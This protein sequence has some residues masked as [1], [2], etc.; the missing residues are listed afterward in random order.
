VRSNSSDNL[1]SSTDS[2]TK[3]SYIDLFKIMLKRK[4]SKKFDYGN[5]KNIIEESEKV[6][7]ELDVTS[8]LNSLKKLKIAMNNLS[9]N[10]AELKRDVF[11]KYKNSNESFAK[12]EL[13]SR[14][15]LM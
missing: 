6:V 8:I 11:F 15:Y 13:T 10:Y 4:S 3:Y 9:K 5:L 2:V 12:K 7:N 1:H 14:N